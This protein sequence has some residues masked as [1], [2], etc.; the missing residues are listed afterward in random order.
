M[1]SGQADHARQA[2]AS[3]PQQQKGLLAASMPQAILGTGG[4]PACRYPTPVPR[5]TFPKKKHSDSMTVQDDNLK[6]LMMSWY[7]AGYYTGL[8][9]GQQQSASTDTQP[10]QQADAG[11][12]ETMKE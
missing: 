10:R 12:E 1:A 4:F 8:Y 11:R 3:A 7:Y 6:N 5:K 9:T 2:E